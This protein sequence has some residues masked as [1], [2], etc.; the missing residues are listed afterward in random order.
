MTI[1]LL[2]EFGFCLKTYE[3][4]SRWAIVDNKPGY[5][6]DL[7]H[8]NTLSDDYDMC[9]T[10]DDFMEKYKREKR[11]NWDHGDYPKIEEIKYIIELKKL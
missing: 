8:I 2:E 5:R 10:E 3:E 4:D 9:K 11:W 1:K 6:N 7:T